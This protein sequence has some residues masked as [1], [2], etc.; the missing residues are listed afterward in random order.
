MTQV[1]QVTRK[2]VREAIEYLHE[3]G[4]VEEMSRDQQHYT[5]ILLKAAANTLN[6]DL[7]L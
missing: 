1:N 2:E 3:N 5:E 4:Y 7:K 6:M